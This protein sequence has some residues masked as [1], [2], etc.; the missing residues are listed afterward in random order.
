LSVP[1]EPH[2]LD[3]DWRFTHATVQWLAELAPQHGETLIL[4]APTVAR[5]LQAS[6]RDVFLVD[7]Q[8]LQ[9]VSNHWARDAATFALPNRAF[10]GAIIDPPW[11]PQYWRLWVTWVARSVGVDRDI[12]VSIWPS[13]TR[14]N[15][16]LEI[17]A[18]DQWL[19]GWAEIE[20]VPF[21][22]RYETPIFEQAAISAAGNKKFTASPGRGR[23]LRIHVKRLPPAE[24]PPVQH[25]TWLRFTINDYQLALRLGPG[26]ADVPSMRRL[27]KTQDWIW[28][29]VS[30]RAPERDLI[31]LWSSRN[32]VAIITS[33]S[34]LAKSIRMA[35]K[36][37]TVEEF[38]RAL[39]NW[40]GLLEWQIP[41][42][43]YRR[44]LEWHH[45]Q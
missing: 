17:N 24:P 19:S 35:I 14:P 40:P 32:E 28:P 43:P 33:S 25:P 29:F 4:G 16:A 12:F 39:L 18:I 37:T 26:F 23:L 22:M 1:P 15:A 45:P 11:Y 5:F 38:E 21:P 3:Y 30:K 2:P 41:R 44:V 31:D 8:P 27:S 42:P 6:K 13:E 10:A 20:S 7:R 36:A 9:G 34:T